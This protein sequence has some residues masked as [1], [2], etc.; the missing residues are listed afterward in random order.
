MVQ[1]I[2]NIIGE[3]QNTL[4]SQ[5]VTRVLHEPPPETPELSAS[6][7]AS[8]PPREPALDEAGSSMP[9]SVVDTYA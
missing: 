4:P 5:T 3:N 9:Q 2:N 1:E 8:E 6:E 7:P